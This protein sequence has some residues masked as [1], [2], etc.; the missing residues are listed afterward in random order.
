MS[1]LVLLSSNRT[2]PNRTEPM[3]SVRFDLKVFNLRFG[4]TWYLS[5]RGSV[6]L[7][8]NKSMEV[9]GTDGVDGKNSWIFSVS[10]IFLREK[11]RKR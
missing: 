3:G 4:S 2:E 9:D 10:G 6:R 11:R 1:G 5:S 8:N 7:E